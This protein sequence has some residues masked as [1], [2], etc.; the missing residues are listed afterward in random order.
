MFCSYSFSFPP[1]PI[2][3]IATVNEINGSNQYIVDLVQS[4]SA[5]KERNIAM[6]LV[7]AKMVRSR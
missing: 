5:S 3:I 1:F 2:G 4:N 6:E 7:A